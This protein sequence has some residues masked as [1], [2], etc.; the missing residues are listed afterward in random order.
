MFVTA[1]RSVVACGSNLDGDFDPLQ[2]DWSDFENNQNWTPS[3]SNNAGGYTLPSGG[4]IVRGMAGARENVIWTL[5]SLWSMR[6]TGSNLDVYAFTEMGK[7]C[8]LI[9][10]NAAALVGGVWYWMTPAGAFYAYG[11]AEPQMLPCTL[12]R[13]V[14]DNLA[15]VQQDKV[16]ASRLVGKNYSEVWW[17]YP[18]MREG[19]ECSR[20]V[21]YDTINGSWSCGTFNRSAYVDATTFEY[22]LAVDTSGQIWFHEKGFTEDG[23]PRSWFVE[24]A[25]NKGPGADAIIIN[26]VKPDSD[27]L[28]GGYQITFTSKNRNARGI[29]TRTYP[30]LNISG[31]TGQKSVRVKGE[32]V[33]MRT[34]GSSAPAF[35]REGATEYDV[36]G[37]VKSK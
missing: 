27:D 20:Y 24:S 35:W 4:R 16:Y 23:G 30:A 2:V 22:P 25:Y 11:G 37:I 3:S 13:D 29:S 21:I 18:D 28:Q 5:E 15:F 34:S 17:F 19:D 32:Q 26:G 33:S 31:A 14:K 1:E 10:P 12:A 7:G 36:I 9:G 8:G 6:P